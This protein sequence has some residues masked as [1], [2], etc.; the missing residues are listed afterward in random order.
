ME[1]GT[2]WLSEV[3]SRTADTYVLRPV[4]THSTT[5]TKKTETIAHTGRWNSVSEDYPSV[6]KSRLRTK[7]SAN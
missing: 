3:S 4:F 6:E 7:K 1:V 5:H 2:I